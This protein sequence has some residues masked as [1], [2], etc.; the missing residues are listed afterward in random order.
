MPFEGRSTMSLRE[1]VCRLALRDG[2][3]R[4][5][6][7][8]RFGITA[9]TLYKW[10]GRFVAEGLAGLED[11]SRRPHSSPGRTVAALEECVLM[12]RESHPAWGGRKIAR[13]LHD[14]GAGEV[15]A[16]SVVTAILRRHGR[17]DPGECAK[18]EPYQ[19][20]ERSRPNELWQMDFKGDFAIGT[21]RCHPLTL[22]D[23]HS[24]FNTCLAACADQ[25]TATV[26]ACLTDAFRR[27]GKPETIL[28]D[29]GS[30]WGD[31]PG[32]GL[33][34]LTVWLLLHDIAVIHGRPYHPQTQGKEERFHQTLKREALAGRSFADLD[35]C[36]RRFDWWRMVYNTERP[37]EAL[38]L[39]TP[40]TRYGP[41]PRSFTEAPPPIEYS[42]LDVVRMVQDRGKVSFKGRLWRL[43]KALK[44]YPVAF[45]PTVEDGLWNVFFTSHRVAQIDLRNPV[46]SDQLV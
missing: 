43:P 1:E 24:R 33:T 17:L 37:H 36:Q 39:A 32:H 45:R 21:G 40:I 8:E 14:L 10:L 3:N 34:P 22:T 9:P 2:A 26:R 35:Q 23:D 27:H 5:Q 38:D 16:P 25:R 7:A 28:A 29:N 44:G 19:R 31:G 6:L 30:P 11:R 41:S 4:R 46:V 20:F 42:A 15:P 13:R 18:R 12:L